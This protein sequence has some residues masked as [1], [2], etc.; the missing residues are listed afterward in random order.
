MWTWTWIHFT[1]RDKLLD[2]VSTNAVLLPTHL[3]SFLQEDHGEPGFQANPFG[4]VCQMR[5]RGVAWSERLI[6][7]NNT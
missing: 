2:D 1:L 6:L 3:V 5:W 4:K 7:R